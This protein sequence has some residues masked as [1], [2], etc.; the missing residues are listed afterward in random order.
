M[1]NQE[2]DH[3]FFSGLFLGGL[4]GAA[5]VFLW[6][7]K[8]GR[9]IKKRLLEK[10]KEVADDWPKIVEDLEK[11]GQELAEKTRQVKKTLKKKAKEFSPTLEKGVKKGLDNFQSEGGVGDHLA[12]KA[13]VSRRFFKRR[14]KRLG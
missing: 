14:G 4:V 9:K 3:P 11:R 2:K 12:E 6:G 10:S 5:A 8:K 7:T 1:T 13:I